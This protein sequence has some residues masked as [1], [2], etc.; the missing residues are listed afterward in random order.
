MFQVC[1]KAFLEILGLKRYRVENIAKQYREEGV[2]P[3]EKRG[4]DHKSHKYLAKQSAVIDF[5]KSLKCSEPHYCRGSSQRLYLPAEL[6]INRSWKMYNVQA[7]TMLKVKRSYFRNKFNTKFNL[8]FGSPQTD[9]CS[10]CLQLLEKIKLTADENI[11]KDLMIQ[12]QFT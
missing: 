1:Q 4:G 3:R 6:S 10:V 12:K 5:I 2:M 9:V 11:K 8:G 7:E